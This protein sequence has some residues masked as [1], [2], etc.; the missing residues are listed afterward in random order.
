[1]KLVEILARE[2][3]EWPATTA[4]YAQDDNGKAYP[5]KSLNISLDNNHNWGR[6]IGGASCMDYSDHAPVVKSTNLAYDYKAAIV[7]REMWEQERV[8]MNEWNGD[9]F[10]PVGTEC[11]FASEG[12]HSNPEYQWCIFHGLLSCG[13]YIIEFHHHTAL[14]RVTCDAFD[15]ITTKFRPIKNPDQIE[16]DGLAEMLCDAYKSMLDTDKVFYKYADAILKAGYRKTG[17]YK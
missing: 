4:C 11:E 16:R 13:G 14:D 6:L 5:F 2:L 15:P 9:G 1:M 12:H 10:P 8:K 3:K 17:D 7:T